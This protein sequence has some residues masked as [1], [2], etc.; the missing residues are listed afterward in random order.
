MANATFVHGDVNPD[1]DVIEQE[2]TLPGMSDS[3]NFSVFYENEDLSARISY[4]W[5]DQFYSGNDQHESPV[6]TEEYYQVYANVSYNV[7]ENFTVFVEALNI[8]EE[9]QRSFVRYEEQLND[10]NQYGA[11]YNIGA[12]YVF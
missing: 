5:R 1:P 10:A 4:N 11:R 6:Y 9:V 12:R 2:F 7:T 3:A 8:T